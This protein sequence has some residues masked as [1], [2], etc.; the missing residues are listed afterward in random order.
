M[1]KKRIRSTDQV[2]FVDFWNL[3]NFSFPFIERRSIVQQER[4]F[5]NSS[6][7]LESFYEDK[8]YIGFLSY[9]SFEGYIYLEHFAINEVH[10]GAGYGSKILRN[11]INETD[12]LVILEI[13]P[14]IDS[15]SQSR[16]NFYKSIGFVQNDF[17]YKVQAYQN[18]TE[19]YDL[20][21]MSLGRMISKD[22]LNTFR[23]DFVDIML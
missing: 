23:K 16:L 19:V 14:I 17:D 1:I 13:D 7:I 11:L 6:Y 10:R 22:E 9:W 3:Y 21:I 20:I 15:I 12:K 18:K 2:E 8:I 4:I 5:T